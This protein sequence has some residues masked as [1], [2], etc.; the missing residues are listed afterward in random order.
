MLRAS[1]LFIMSDLKLI[2][3]TREEVSGIVMKITHDC[4][5]GLPISEI[6]LESDLRNDLNLD[7]LDIL[8][9]FSDITDTFGIEFND[10]EASDFCTVKDVVD[11]V[12]RY[13]NIE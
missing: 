4:V 8:S 11:V 1:L 10:E 9:I 3:M 5:S 2:I 13:L 7:S 6:K 12:C